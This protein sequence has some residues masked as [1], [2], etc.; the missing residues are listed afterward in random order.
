MRKKSSATM[1]QKS[2]EKWP[3]C[4]YEIRK[5]T[6]AEVGRQQE[7]RDLVRGGREKAF[8]AYSV[9]GTKATG[10]IGSH[11]LCSAVRP[12]IL[13]AAI[14]TAIMNFKQALSLQ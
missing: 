5:A 7:T 11:L 4:D 10:A 14:A 2:I 8:G 13:P 6:S 12:A 1:D 3:T 9:T